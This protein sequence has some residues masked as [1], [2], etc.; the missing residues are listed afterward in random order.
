MI[1]DEITTEGKLFY[2]NQ[3]NLQFCFKYFDKIP[4]LSPYGYG[5]TIWNFIMF[6]A[7]SFKIFEIPLLIA[8]SIEIDTSTFYLYQIP[9]FFIFILEIFMQFNIGFIKEG[10]VVLNRQK[11]KENY[12]R[13][14]FIWDLISCSFFLLSI[15]FKDS[16]YGLPVL[17]RSHQIQVIIQNAEL[18]LQMN[19][20]KS[21]V[22]FIIF[23]LAKLLSKKK[24]P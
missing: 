14:K 19:S 9:L 13:G 12:L 16:L 5:F 10:L 24:F 20:I 22:V 3:K 8:F 1:K 4:I 21:N 18:L 11:I 2:L 17:L 15:L 7:I 23:S 6:C